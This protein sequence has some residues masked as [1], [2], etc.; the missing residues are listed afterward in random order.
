MTVVSFYASWRASGH[1]NR[2]HPKPS[3]REPKLIPKPH[4]TNVEMLAPEIDTIAIKSNSSTILTF[5][6]ITFCLYSPNR[7][8]DAQPTLS[9]PLILSIWAWASWITLILHRLLINFRAGP[10]VGELG[11]PGGLA[12]WWACAWPAKYNGSITDC[13]L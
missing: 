5:H 4:P 13:H 11:Q 8:P 2:S 1:P 9:D 12:G 6:I 10:G 7:A 3:P